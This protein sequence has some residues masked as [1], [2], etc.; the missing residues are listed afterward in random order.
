MRILIWKFEVL[1]NWSGLWPCLFFLTSTLVSFS[2]LPALLVCFSLS[3]QVFDPLSSS[4]KLTMISYMCCPAPWSILLS[5][6]SNS[7]RSGFNYA[8][9]CLSCLYSF[10]I[11]K[12]TGVCQR[13]LYLHNQIRL[14]DFLTLIP[15]RLVTKIYVQFFHSVLTIAKLMPSIYLSYR[16]PFDFL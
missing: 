12:S 14:Y 3:A 1:N 10:A 5:S 6:R 15:P 7:F 11:R 2:I 8:Y 16:N 9:D 4:T 13:K